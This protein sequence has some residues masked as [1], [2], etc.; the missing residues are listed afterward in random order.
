MYSCPPNILRSER[1]SHV[2]RATNR[3]FVNDTKKPSLE[4]ACIT[5]SPTY[6]CNIGCCPFFAFFLALFLEFP[7]L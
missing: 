3:V 4:H 7:F 1:S 5:E 2:T 6:K